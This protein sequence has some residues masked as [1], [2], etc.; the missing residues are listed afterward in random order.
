M[1]FKLTTVDTTQAAEFA[2]STCK[3]RS[4]SFDST[5]KADL[6]KTAAHHIQMLTAS[7]EALVEEVSGLVVNHFQDCSDLEKMDILRELGIDQPSA[8][9]QVSLKVSG[10]L[11]EDMLQKLVSET[12][13]EMSDEEAG[14]AISDVAFVAVDEA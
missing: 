13:M 5:N 4:K 11:T 2:A 12:F 14:L 9:V 7:L 10:R 6:A 1:T 8:S 3:P